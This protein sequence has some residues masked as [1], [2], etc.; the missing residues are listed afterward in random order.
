MKKLLVG[1]YIYIYKYIYILYKSL[2]MEFNFF[3]ASMH[4]QEDFSYAFQ[5]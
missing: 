3:M 2:E 1:V 4:V 5:A